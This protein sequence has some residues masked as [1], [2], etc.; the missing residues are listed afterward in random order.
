MSRGTE[1]HGMGP[2]EFLARD[3]DIPAADS[4]EILELRQLPLV[5]ATRAQL[6]WKLGVRSL[7]DIAALDETT[8]RHDPTVNAYP[9]G[10]L[11][12][13]FPLIQGFAKALAED[14]PLVY[15]PEPMFEKLEGPIWY[16]DLEFIAGTGEVFLWGL[17]EDGKDEIV[18]WFE[19]TKAGQHRALEDFK[20]LVETEDP[21]F[22]AYGSQA[23]DEVSIREA[24]KRHKM[25]GQ[26]LKDMRFCDILKRVIFTES[27][28]TQRVYLPVRKLK[29]EHVA[30]FF[31]YEKPKNISVRDGYHA[32]K[33]YQRYRRNPDPK[34]ARRLCEYNAEDLYQ[35]EILFRGLEKLFRDQG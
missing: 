8:F 23:S 32:L 31:G 18:Q 4:K 33:M 27:P 25:E 12:D 15:G 2:K 1:T 22:V 14:R 30:R 21:L 26:W 11:I 3:P 24:A 28:E 17:K 13:A 9:D 6:F 35:T 5:G 34:I 7:A 16:L 19:H 10:S 20:E 29:C